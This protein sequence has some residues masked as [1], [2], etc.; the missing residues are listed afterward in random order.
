MLSR[1]FAC[2]GRSKQGGIPFVAD[3]TVTVVDDTRVAV[4]CKRP[5]LELVSVLV[6]VLASVSFGAPA[7][8]AAA[9]FAFAFAFA[10]AA[11]A[12]AAVALWRACACFVRL[13]HMPARVRCRPRRSHL[14]RLHAQCRPTSARL[15]QHV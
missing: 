7:A 10:V 3:K 11:L 8:A 1:A 12:A 13:R 14:V 9:A 5:A 2:I 6:C 4:G 15:L